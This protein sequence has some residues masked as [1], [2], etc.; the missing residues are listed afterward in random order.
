M[1]EPVNSVKLP[2]SPEALKLYRWIISDNDE[3]IA[4]GDLLRIKEGREVFLLAKDIQLVL[5]ESRNTELVNALED[6]LGLFDSGWAV[7][8]TTD[9]N[10]PG[11]AM[12]QLE[13]VRKLVSA[14]TLITKLNN[15]T[16]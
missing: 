12:R 5:N 15:P 6:V 10:K 8:D 1:S 9:D 4:K 7:R 11:F 3:E 16:V 13:P 2:F 14:R